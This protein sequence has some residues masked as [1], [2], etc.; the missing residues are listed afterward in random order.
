MVTL[1][2]IARESLVKFIPAKITIASTLFGI[3]QGPVSAVKE[4]VAKSHAD[5]LCVLSRIHQGEALPIALLSTL[6]SVAGVRAVAQRSQ[7]TGT[8]PPATNDL[9]AREFL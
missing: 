7:L 6:Q 5:R 4:A 2:G 3:L 8:S 9:R 1:G